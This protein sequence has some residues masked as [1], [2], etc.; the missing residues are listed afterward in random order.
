M[1]WSRLDKS[2]GEG[3]G[4]KSCWYGVGVVASNT[5]GDEYNMTISCG[6]SLSVCADALVLVL[7]RWCCAVF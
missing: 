7:V 5:C 6:R 2:E 4:L 3:D 1:G